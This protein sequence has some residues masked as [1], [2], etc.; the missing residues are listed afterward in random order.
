MDY[1]LIKASDVKEHFK[2][3]IF[4]ADQKIDT[5]MGRF[6]PRRVRGGGGVVPGV[7]AQG[8]GTRAVSREK[9]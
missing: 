9:R 1:K 3:V 4:G 6:H 7:Q 5:Y 2:R 8:M